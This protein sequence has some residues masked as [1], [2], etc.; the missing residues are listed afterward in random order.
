MLALRFQF[1]L[2][3][4]SVYKKKLTFYIFIKITLLHRLI[5]CFIVDNRNI[6]IIN[7][8]KILDKRLIRLVVNT[9]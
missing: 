8:N 3:I 9:K 1:L 5:Y 7:K 2:L 4:L 6:Q